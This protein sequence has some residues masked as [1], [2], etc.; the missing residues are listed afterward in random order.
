MTVSFILPSDNYGRNVLHSTDGIID[1]YT[2]AD[3]NG[4][5]IIVEFPYLTPVDQVYN[6]INSMPPGD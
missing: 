4:T 1:T 6:V 2:V 5:R 3:D